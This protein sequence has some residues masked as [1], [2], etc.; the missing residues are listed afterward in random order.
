MRRRSGSA[1]GEF[2]PGHIRDRRTLPPRAFD[3]LQAAARNKEAAREPAD[4]DAILKNIPFE[5]WESLDESE[6]NKLVSIA[7]E[8]SPLFV[9]GTSFDIGSFDAEF[10]RLKEK[11]AQFGEVISTSPAVDEKAP[12]KINFRILYAVNTDVRTVETAVSDFGEVVFEEIVSADN[13]PGTAKEILLTSRV[14]A[15]LQGSQTSFARISTDWIGSFPQRT[16]SCEPLRRPWPWPC[17]NCRSRAKSFI[18]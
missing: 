16:P 18:N 9:V 3:R 5:I 2:D 11:L 15:S 8:G 17:P 13:N 12:D 4:S 7:A 10:F 6:K 14:P 1:L